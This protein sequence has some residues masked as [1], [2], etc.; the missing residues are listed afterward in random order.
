MKFCYRI[1]FNLVSIIYD[2][3]F[4]RLV[5]LHL[6]VIVSTSCKSFVVETCIKTFS[7]STQCLELST[8]KLNNFSL[9]RF[10]RLL[11]AAVVGQNVLTAHT[12]SITLFT[13]HLSVQ[14]RPCPLCIKSYFC[15]ESCQCL[16]SLA[17]LLICCILFQ[18]CF[19]QINDDDD[20]DDDE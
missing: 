13:V 1:V 5:L 3:F 11:L 16:I 17:V 18:L 7:L 9:L 6:R 19:E 20:D 2:D 14:R 10:S 8:I 4:S 12:S 15:K